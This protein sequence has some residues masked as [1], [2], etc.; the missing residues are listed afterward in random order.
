MTKEILSIKKSCGDTPAE[1]SLRIPAF[2]NFGA[3]MGALERESFDMLMARQAGQDP[4]TP[5]MDVKSM[6]SD[7]VAKQKESI[8]QL[9]PEFAGLGDIMSGLFSGLENL[10]IDGTPPVFEEK[11]FESLNYD[12]QELCVVLPADYS[13]WDGEAE[14]KLD[15]F[16]A[17]WAEI[18]PRVSQAL[19][20]YYVNWY[21]QL[22][23]YNNPI[24]MPAPG[25]PQLVDDRARI[26]TIYLN[27]DGSVGLSGQCTWEDEHG[28]GVLI[29]DGKVIDCG[30]AD[31]ADN[32]CF[33]EE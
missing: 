10:E 32:E 14:A 18:R 23:R 2:Q 7:M 12:L 1:A 13:E 16:L 29:K 22:E 6:I 30:Y 27:K 25:D 3:R 15:Q 17:G 31:V 24:L 5:P 28:L 9:P 33:D 8:K 4:T 20:D 11:D 26:T 19:Y 21:P